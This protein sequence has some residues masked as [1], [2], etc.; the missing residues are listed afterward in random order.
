MVEVHSGRLLADRTEAV[1]LFDQLLVA[2]RVDAV[3]ANPKEVVVAA[4]ETICDLPHAVI[5]AGLAV[6]S[7]SVF[8]GPVV[9]EFVDRF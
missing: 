4:V 7:L 8:G 9:W 2:G 5:V 6:G 1:L 3:A